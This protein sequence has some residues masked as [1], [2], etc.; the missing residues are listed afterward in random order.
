[1]I[2]IVKETDGILDA[3]NDY[4]GWAADDERR[5]RGC[6]ELPAERV[7]VVSGGARAV[8]KAALDRTEGRL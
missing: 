3:R 4:R 8:A 1:M 7:R 6:K 5:L 2:R